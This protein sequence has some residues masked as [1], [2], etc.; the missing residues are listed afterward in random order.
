M[1]IA[2][3]FLKTFLENREKESEKT[4]IC[5][6]RGRVNNQKEREK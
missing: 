1:L 3:M 4:K 5:I 2:W 6:E